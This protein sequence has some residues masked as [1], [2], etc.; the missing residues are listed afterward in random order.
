MLIF[1]ILLL[2]FSG[3]NLFSVFE[4]VLGWLGL[5]SWAFDD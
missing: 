2:I 4:K 3:L 1:P 5:T